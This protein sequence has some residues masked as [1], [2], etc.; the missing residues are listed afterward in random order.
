[1]EGREIL[2]NIQSRTLYD[3]DKKWRDKIAITEKAV[4]RI[5]NEQ[6]ATINATRAQELLIE[7]LPKPPKDDH[8]DKSF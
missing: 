5:R 6:K 1:M 4:V 8:L 2:E 3:E 7:H